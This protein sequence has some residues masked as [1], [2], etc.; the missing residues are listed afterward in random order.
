[1]NHE[2]FTRLVAE[3]VKKQVT[4]EQAQYIR[5][6]EN[7]ERWQH[8]LVAL[9][10]NLSEQ[11][12][13]LNDREEADSERYKELGD[14]GLGMLAE[15]QSDVEQRR[16][17]IFRFRYHV[18]QRLDEATRLLSSIGPDPDAEMLEFVRQGIEQHKSLTK[19]SGIDPTP[20]DEA[21]WNT[22]YGKWEFDSIDVDSIKAEY[23]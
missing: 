2:A 17:K 15:M 23:S 14:E 18:E 13:I 10:E 6:G 22:L 7:L 8:A 5:Q 4:P 9:L 20:I 1:M 11:L 12:Q 19:R 16:K 3:D 21:L